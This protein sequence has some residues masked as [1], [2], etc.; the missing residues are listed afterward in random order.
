M[1]KFV[2][3]AFAIDLYSRT[4][5]GL[6]ELTETLA[7]ER[8]STSI[9]SIGDVY[10]NDAETVIGRVTGPGTVT[11]VPGRQHTAAVTT[12]LETCVPSGR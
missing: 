12:G 6:V 1:T 2:Y 7:L 3:I 8:L 10:D 11:G 9:G 5:V 4:I